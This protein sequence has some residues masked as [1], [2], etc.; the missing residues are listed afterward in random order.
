MNNMK[1]Y[2]NDGEIDIFKV[3]FEA[4]DI[5][6]MVAPMLGALVFDQ[7]GKQVCVLLDQVKKIEFEVEED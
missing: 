3:D 6:S 2:Y 4:Y 1:V 7:D 5:E